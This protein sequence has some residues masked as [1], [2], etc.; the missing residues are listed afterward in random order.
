VIIKHRY[1]ENVTL[2]IIILNSIVLCVSNPRVSNDGAFI[3]LTEVLF[4]ILYSVEMGLKIMGLGFILNRGSYLRDWWNV[5]DFVIVGSAYIPYLL[6]S[7][8]GSGF[9]L[10]GL[11]ALRI[12]RPLR[13]ISSVKALKV[14][15]KAFFASLPMLCDTFAVLLFVFLIFAI[16]GLQLFSGY[17]KK[18]CFEE[19]TGIPIKS[20]NEEDTI[21]GNT[22]CPDGYFCGKGLANPL[23]G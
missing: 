22:A 16:A 20:D 15:L 5:L 11:R 8:G 7:S 12:L 3:D 14:I 13:T 17:L 6:P 19:T 2:L 4:L 18:R 23:G 21:C 10:A 9:S 1:F